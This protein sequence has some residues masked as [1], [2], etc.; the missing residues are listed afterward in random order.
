MVEN[1]LP[2][3]RF[4]K[5]SDGELAYFLGRDNYSDDIFLLPSR[6][7]G[8]IYLEIGSGK[9]SKKG[10]ELVLHP[11]WVY[12]SEYNDE[13]DLTGFA[14]IIKEVKSAEENRIKNVT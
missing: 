10:N 6:E 13:F 9:L 5:T 11:W 14:K 1:Y 2:D 3:G 12:E 7:D 8:E 4:V